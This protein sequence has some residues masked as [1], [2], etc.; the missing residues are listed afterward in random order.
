MFGHGLAIDEGDI[1]PSVDCILWPLIEDGFIRRAIH[2]H[3]THISQTA[4]E[5]HG[6]GLSSSYLHGFDELI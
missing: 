6:E 4:S 2:P 5:T 3:G 1:G